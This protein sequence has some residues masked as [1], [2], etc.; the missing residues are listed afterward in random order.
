MSHAKARICSRVGVVAA[1]ACAA[2]YSAGLRAHHS[3]AEYDA[4]TF[5]EARGEVVKVLWQNP[6]IRLEIST[7]RFDGVSELWLLEGQNP[8]RPRPRAHPAQH[9]QGRR[10]GDV[11]RQPIDAPRAPDV[12]HE[13]VVAGRNGAR[14]ARKC[15][16]ALVAEP[17]LEPHASDRGSRA[18]GSGPCRRHLPRLATDRFQDSGLGKRSAAHRRRA[19]GVAGVRRGARRPRHRLHAARHAAGHHAQRPVRDS[20]RADGRRHRIEERV[21]RDRSSH[22][23]D[24]ANRCCRTSSAD[25]ARLLDGEMG[26]RSRSS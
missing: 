25:S 7:A 6:H 24:G 15:C 18:C 19:R 3:T 8:D 1:F 13:R 16:A 12:C 10:L 22:S 21:P 26:R 9:R 14:A 17:L 5:V 20:L 23:H 2:A 4:A 11:R